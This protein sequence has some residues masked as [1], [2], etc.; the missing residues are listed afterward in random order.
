MIFKC[1]FIEAKGFLLDTCHTCSCVHDQLC[2]HASELQ[3][4]G[5]IENNSKIIFLISQRK[6]ML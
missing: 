2:L 5:E 4:R 1:A 6:P 3:I